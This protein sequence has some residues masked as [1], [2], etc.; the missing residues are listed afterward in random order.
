MPA[1]FQG[2]LGSGRTVGNANASALQQWVPTGMKPRHSACSTRCGPGSRRLVW[3]GLP[4]KEDSSW[5][6]GLTSWGGAPTLFIK[7]NS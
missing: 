6:V 1:A 2:P 3:Q 7:G 4:R 5:G